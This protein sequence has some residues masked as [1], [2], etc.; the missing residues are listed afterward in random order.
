MAEGGRRCDEVRISACRWANIEM[1][2]ARL[3]RGWGCGWTG[4]T[5]DWRR[6]C[7]GWLLWKTGWYCCCIGSC[8]SWGRIREISEKLRFAVEGEV[9]VRPSKDGFGSEIVRRPL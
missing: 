6:H 3:H 4:K 8:P 1:L 2:V 5:N 9:R 7:Y